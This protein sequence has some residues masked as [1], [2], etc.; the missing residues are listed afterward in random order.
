VEAVAV[1]EVAVKV[2]EAVIAVVEV[3]TA[4]AAVVMVV[5]VTVGTVMV[6]QGILPGADLMVVAGGTRFGRHVVVL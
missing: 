2:A 3:D 1:T 6:D 5:D 4:A